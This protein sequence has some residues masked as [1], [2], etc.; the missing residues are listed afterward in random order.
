MT[1]NGFPP[2]PAFLLP[3]DRLLRLSLLLLPLLVPARGASAQTGTVSTDYNISAGTI[4]SSGLR[5][6]SADYTADFSTTPGTVLA[7]A[8]YTVRT[9]GGGQLYDIAGLSLAATPGH[10]PETA[11]TRLTVS[12]LLDDR[13]TFP[14]TAS[15]TATVAWT[16]LNGPLAE[17]D[18]AGA[19][20]ADVVYQDTSVRVQ[21]AFAGLTGTLDLM[22]TDTITD[23]FPGYAG[24]GLPDDWQ[25][26]YFQNSQNGSGIGQTGDF[27]RD[28]LNNLLEFAFGTDPASR[29]SG[30]GGILYSGGVIISRGQPVP[31]VA[32]I[33]NSVDFRVIFGRRRDYQA[34]GLTYKIQFS[35]NL[36]SWATSTAIP[37]VVAQDEDFEAVSV[38]WPFFVDGR[39][40]RFF[41]AV[42]ISAP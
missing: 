11:A 10:V 31:L 12:F 18:G 21:A 9:G 33:I 25:F 41:R 2:G 32:N 27:D 38:P 6:T 23:N 8:D 1:R 14:L 22:V 3:H 7:S 36:R 16:I 24:D 4:H 34:A 39:K 5:A 35:A 42:V 17:P 20:I 29:T 40:A 13:T 30:S 26:R 19:A 15:Q 28:G 37:V